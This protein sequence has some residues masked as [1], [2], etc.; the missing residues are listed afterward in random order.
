M[1]LGFRVWVAGNETINTT[2]A[3]S[4]SRDALALLS[5]P[6]TRLGTGT[7]GF[8][9][10]RN[11]SSLGCLSDSL[12]IHA[13]ARSAVAAAAAGGIAPSAASAGARPGS[14][15]VLVFVSSHE[16]TD[17][18]D[19]ATQTQCLC[20]VGDA[21]LATFWL[22]A[23]RGTGIVRVVAAVVTRSSITV[24][25]TGSAI[26]GVPIIVVVV[27]PS[28]PGGASGAAWRF[29]VVIVA[30]TS[31]VVAPSWR[32]EV[33]RDVFDALVASTVDDFGAAWT[34]ALSALNVCFFPDVIRIVPITW[35][36]ANLDESE[37]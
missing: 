7:P 21:G 1:A 3:E 15:A 16:A 13:A 14:R 8:Q 22:A 29:V 10:A 32:G 27:V 26:I 23:G 17:G 31:T 9:G 19:Q 20:N 18:S 30:I 35:A 34:W 5:R 37:C 6:S 2:S 12:L 11:Q 24:A 36:G 25:A 33:T 28:A 4:S